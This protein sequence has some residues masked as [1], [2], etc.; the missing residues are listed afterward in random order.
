MFCKICGTQL[1]DDSKFCSN[2]G[3]KTEETISN[4]NAEIDN[5]QTE[6]ECEIINALPTNRIEES[7]N[8]I[9]NK[10]FLA[11]FI[12][13]TF[14]TILFLGIVLISFIGWGEV[15]LYGGYDFTSTLTTIS[16]VFMLIGFVVLTYMFIINLQSKSIKLLTK[17]FLQ[18]CLLR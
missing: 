13:A 12:S 5:I 2:C 11:G 18:F 1:S 10:L 7:C 16:L 15:Y 8:K 14:G 9:S 17:K 4:E 3:Y 6:D